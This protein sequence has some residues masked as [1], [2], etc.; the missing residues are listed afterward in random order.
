MLDAEVRSA[1]HARLAR[2][3]GYNPNRTLII[4]ELA[5]AGQVRIDTAVLNGRFAGYEIKSAKDTL[6]RLPKQV[7]LYSAV[8]DHATLVVAENHKEKAVDLLP[9]WWGVI[10]VRTE[11][12]GSLRLVQARRPRLNQ[13]IEPEILCRLLWRSESLAALT[14]SGFD[15][16][17]RSKP[18]RA[19][20][21]RLASTMPRND[22]VDLVRETLK[23][24][25]GW[26]ADAA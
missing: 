22:L 10:E 11:R 6:R 13:D 4:D 18:R 23:S 9:D 12:N 3:H 21:E 20:S 17:F 14:R 1:L 19:I 24:R 2:S 25:A 15:A 5:I 16:G 8:L 26:R 7:E